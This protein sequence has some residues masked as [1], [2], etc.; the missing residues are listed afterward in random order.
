KLRSSS[1]GK[2]GEEKFLYLRGGFAVLAEA[3][4]ARIRELGGGVELNATV[5][6]I[7][8][9]GDVWRITTSDMTIE[10]KKVIATPALPI[11]ADMVRGW[12]SEDYIR[13]LERIRYLGNVCLILELDRS[14]TSSY[15][16]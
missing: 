15:W 11:I 16:I 3:L 9:D 6:G 1:R 12:A 2:Q 7:V 4:A 13:R 8:P 5:S 14:L 10:A